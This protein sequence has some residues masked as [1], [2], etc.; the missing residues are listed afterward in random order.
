MA[1]YTYTNE[2]GT[3]RR[4]ARRIIIDNP[5]GGTP[6]ITFETEDRII[7]ADK[8]EIFVPQDDVIRAIDTSTLTHNF[9]KFNIATGDVSKETRKGSTLMGLIFPALTDVFID[10]AMKAEEVQILDEGE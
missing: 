10:T 7:M 9:S 3:S 4:R 6:I 5:S 8:S 2:P 1:N